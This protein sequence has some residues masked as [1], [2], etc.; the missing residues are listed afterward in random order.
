V[1]PGANAHFLQ[2][3]NLVLKG[4]IS[5][6]HLACHHALETAQGVFHPFA[7]SWL[8]VAYSIFLP[9]ARVPL[10]LPLLRH[11]ALQAHLGMSGD[12]GALLTA[13][14]IALTNCGQDIPLARFP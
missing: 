8:I 4:L 13:P 6:G 14:P 11:I 5:S 2:V 1:V 3:V 10:L 7:V 9:A 12:Q